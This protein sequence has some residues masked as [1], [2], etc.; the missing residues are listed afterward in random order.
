MLAYGLSKSEVVDQLTWPEIE[1]LLLEAKDWREARL[2]DLAVAF[3]EP[4]RLSKNTPRPEHRDPDGPV[5]KFAAG[6]AQI[7]RLTGQEESARRIELRS[8]ASWLMKQIKV[9]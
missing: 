4:E 1:F 8:K 2:F 5:D 7:A 9:E 3:H 6:L